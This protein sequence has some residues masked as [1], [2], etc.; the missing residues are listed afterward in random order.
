MGFQ[1]FGLFGALLTLLAAFISSVKR[2][3]SWYSFM[4]SWVIS[5]ISYTLLFFGGQ[6]KEHKPP[7]G[8]CMAQASLIY[9]APPHTAA[10]TLGLVV[11]IWFSVREGLGKKPF[12][13]QRIWT[14]VLLFVPWIL[15][16]L[17]VIESLTIAALNL[18]TV[19]RTGSGMYCNTKII[20]PGRISA[21]LV[22]IILIPAVI[23]EVIIILS[24]RKKWKSLREQTVASLAIRVTLFVIFGFF[25]IV[26]SVTFT[27]MVQK[28]AELNIVVS[29]IPVA[30]ILIFGTQ[31]DLMNAWMF[32]RWRKR[33][34]EAMEAEAAQATIPNGS[35]PARRVLIE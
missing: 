12:S 34:L 17:I 21:A 10:S 32:W 8:L 29:I 7:L 3:G 33:R 16:V 4:V 30:A 35:A 18:K 20:I 19:K 26:L 1:L 25:A 15:W 9:A 31:K 13:G 27:F 24:I 22:S 6:L 2:Y 11:Q 14:R 23:V 5:S 28:G